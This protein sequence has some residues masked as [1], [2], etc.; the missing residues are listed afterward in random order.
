MSFW[1]ELVDRHARTVFGLAF[2]IVGNVHDAEDVAQESF[3]E[4]WELGRRGTVTDWRG[5][6][7][8]VATFRALD[9]VRRRRTHSPLDGLQA[10]PVAEPSAQLEA[11]ELSER[12]QAALPELPRQAAAVFVLTYFDQRTRDE[13]AALLDMA[14]QA[15]S[16]ALFKA[17]KRL[18]ELL[19]A[20]PSRKEVFHETE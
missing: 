2:R 7:C 14:P 3:R 20:Q 1:Q 4:T 6:L 11:L 17:R 19:L 18:H 10:S 8:R 12:L 9:L 15:V 16:V 5:C 13:V